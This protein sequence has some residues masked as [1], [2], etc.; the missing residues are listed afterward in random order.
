MKKRIL[1]I[2]SVLALL[3]AGCSDWLDLNHNPDALEEVPEAHV[4]LPAAEVGIANNLMGWDFGFGGGFWVQYWTQSY[5]ASQ[6]KSLCEYL[7]QDFNTAYTSLT[8]EPLADLQRIKSMTAE[9]EN[10]GY[11]FVAEALSIFTWQMI[12]DVWGDMPY[13]EALRG[14]EQIFNPKQDTGKDIYTDLLKR[15]DELLAVDLSNSSIDAGQDLIYGGDLAKWRKFATALKLKLMLRLSQTQEYNNAAVLSF[16]ESASF[17]SESAKIS[18]SVWNDEMEG[19]RHPMREFQA[20]G[21]NYISQNVRA[22]KSFFDYLNDNDD[23]RLAK[24]FSGSEAAFF[25][26]FDSKKDADGDGTTDD[27][28]S[29]ATVVFPANMDLMIMSAWEVN[30]YLAEVYARAGNDAKAKEHYDA[31]VQASLT[32]HG[33]TD[34]SIVAAGGYAAWTGGAAEAKI[35]QIAMQKWVANCNYQH[36]ESFLERNRTKYPSVS[37]IDVNANR[38]AAWDNFPVGQLTISVEGRAIL[39][40]NLPASPLYPEAYIFRNSNAP[41]QKPNVGQKVWWD[42]KAGK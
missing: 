37:E 28:E 11:F 42:K 41:S 25:G 13:F 34:F 30:F 14:D 1:I 5:T 32:Q 24:L 12:T 8:A 21:A 31:A 20:G 9:D 40:G 2:W 39:N 4:L 17:L 27:K 19:K 35:Q 16:V 26:D 7:P 36:I 6:F 3:F 33:I 18:G 10:K 15:V 23:P 22:C 29:Y 38:P